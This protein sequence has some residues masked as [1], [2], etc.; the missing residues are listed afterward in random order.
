MGGG[1]GGPRGAALPAPQLAKLRRLVD[2]HGLMTVHRVLGL[3][4]TTVAQA[5]AGGG[6]RSGTIALLVARIDALPDLG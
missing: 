2:H 3:S 4:R 5:A 1:R 6:L